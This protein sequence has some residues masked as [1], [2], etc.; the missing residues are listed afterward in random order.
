MPAPGKD[1]ETRADHR[2]ERETQ[3]HD[4]APVV[5]VR[6]RTGNEHQKQRRKELHQSHDAEVEGIAGNVIDLPAHRNR[7]DLRRQAHHETRY[8]IETEPMV[9]KGELLGRWGW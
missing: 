8:P 6:R 4:D 7:D 2:L 5:P 3:A 9:A 1:D